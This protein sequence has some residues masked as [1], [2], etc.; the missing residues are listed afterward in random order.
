MQF[1]EIK[2]RSQNYQEEI[3]LRDRL[4]REPLGLTF[5]EDDLQ[6]ESNQHHFGI[7]ANDQLIACV[8]A[9]PRS[10]DEVKIRQMCVDEAYQSQGIGTMLMTQVEQRLIELGFRR[11]ILHARMEATEF[12]RKLGYSMFGEPFEEVT[13]PHW[14]MEKKLR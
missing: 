4:L 8:V 2:W 1:I 3:A 11:A 12:Y 7:T 9:V 13:I 14:A 5:S 10:K 6:R